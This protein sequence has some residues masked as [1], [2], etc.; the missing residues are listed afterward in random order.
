MLHRGVVAF[1]DASNVFLKSLLSFRGV[2]RGKHSPSR[3][4]VQMRDPCANHY[5]EYSRSPHLQRPLHLMSPPHK[6]ATE[7]TGLVAL[8]PQLAAALLQHNPHRQAP[9]SSHPRE[10]FPRQR[11]PRANVSTPQHRLEWVS[12]HPR[13]RFPSQRP[14]RANVS[15]PQHRLEW[16][17]L[18]P[19]PAKEP[20]R[21]G[22]PPALR[23]QDV[24]KGA[25]R[26]VEQQWLLLPFARPT[27]T[28]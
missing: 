3:T 26:A 23:Q 20:L 4:T 8:L 13:A 27:V 7:A 12:L 25:L 11:Q 28:L 24:S 18:H 9:V 6:G 22:H 14:P 1:R 15:T 16:V 10:R 21:L 2:R 17:S 5:S 19:P